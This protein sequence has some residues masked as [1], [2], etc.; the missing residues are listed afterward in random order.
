MVAVSACSG[1]YQKA[2]PTKHMFT[3]CR[4][5]MNKKLSSKTIKGILWDIMTANVIIAKHMI[6]HIQVRVM[7]L[8]P[9]IQ[10]NPEYES[11]SLYVDDDKIFY[12]LDNEVQVD[13]NIANKMASELWVEAF[14]ARTKRR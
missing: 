9:V 12:G 13:V 1:L 10:D 14:S 2:V 7:K 4:Q 8:L 3:L 5:G 6:Y 11:F